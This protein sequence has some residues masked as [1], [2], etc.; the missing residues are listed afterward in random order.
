MLCHIAQLDERVAISAS[1]QGF[2]IKQGYP[3]YQ[4]MSESSP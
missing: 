4:E 1:D 2:D 3:R